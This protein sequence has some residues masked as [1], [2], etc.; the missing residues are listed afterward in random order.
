M[1]HVQPLDRTFSWRAAALAVGLILVIALAAVGAWALIGRLGGTSS[2]TPP[3]TRH[4][5]KRTP[6]VPL[7]PR[8]RVSVLVLNANGVAHA[9][10]NEASRLLALGYANAIGSNA[11]QG[12]AASMVLFRP[13]WQGEAERLAHDARI[14]LV[15][16]LDGHL[17][18]ADAGD[19][20]VVV[21]GR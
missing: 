3:A 1:E 2:T 12:F 11:P 14:G 17:P 18:A 6:T 10:G 4:D 5:H 21:L 13:G 19:Q 20:L 16:P 15:R 8:S 9:A 7:R